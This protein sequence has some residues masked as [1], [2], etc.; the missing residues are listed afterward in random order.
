MAALVVPVVKALYPTS[1]IS[2][3]KRL[4]PHLLA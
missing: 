4:V 2:K 3:G 1:D